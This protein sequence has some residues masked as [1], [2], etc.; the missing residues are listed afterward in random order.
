MH[1]P[2]CRAN[3]TAAVVNNRAAP[4][5]QRFRYKPT[6]KMLFMRVGIQ[7]RPSDLAFENGRAV[8][9]VHH[10]EICARHGDRSLFLRA[11]QVSDGVEA[12]LWR[13]LGSTDCV[14]EQYRQ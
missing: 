4:M 11:R 3:V 12:N 1:E 2:T 6:C 5:R 7:N 8:S 14:P 13:Y 10:G 9:D